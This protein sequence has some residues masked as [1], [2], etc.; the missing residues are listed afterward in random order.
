[1]LI[2]ADTSIVG[3]MVVDELCRYCYFSILR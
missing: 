1:M 3:V 2:I